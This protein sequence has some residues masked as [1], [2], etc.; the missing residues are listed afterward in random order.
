MRVVLDTNVL[1]SAALKEN[2]VP[3]AAVHLVLERGTLLKSDLTAAELLGVLDRPYLARLI[4]PRHRDWIIA[5]LT[6][7]ERVSIAEG[8]AVCRD[9]DDDK[10]LEL[11]VSGH[12]DLIVSG[13][14]DLLALNPFRDIPI[15]T[16][17]AFVQGATR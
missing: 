4:A 9:P 1:V 17:A 11:A 14:A 10:Y 2:S 16:P 12:A 7:A 5:T 8:I 13:D 6:A 15:V 3:A